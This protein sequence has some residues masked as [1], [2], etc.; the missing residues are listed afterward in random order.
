MVRVAVARDLVALV[1]HPTDHL[2]ITLSHLDQFRDRLMFPVDISDWP[3]KI[4]ELARNLIRLSGLEPDRDAVFVLHGPNKAL[5]LCG[6]RGA[7]A[8]APEQR[9]VGYDAAA[10]CAAL[11]AAEPSWPLGAHAVTM[12]EAWTDPTVTAGETVVRAFHLTELRRALEEVYTATSQPPPLY[13]AATISPGVTV[14]RATDIAELR[15]AVPPEGA[16]ATST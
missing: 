7:Y 11:A 5:G 13:T 16:A 9:R 15:A 1:D 3:V 4:V 2:R 14:V 10:W 6:L 8:I 12:L